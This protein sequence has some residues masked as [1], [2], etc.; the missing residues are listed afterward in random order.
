MAFFVTFRGGGGGG[1]K[2]YVAMHDVNFSKNS[3]EM[4]P[5]EEVILLLLIVKCNMHAYL[6]TE[7]TK[8][9]VNIT[10]LFLQ[11]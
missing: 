11:C 10:E 1:P 4:P 6:E 8:T 3:L 2:V 7:M 9:V 5:N